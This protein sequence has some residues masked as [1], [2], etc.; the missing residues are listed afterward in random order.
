MRKLESSP[1]TMCS[2]C[3]AHPGL[4]AIE[5][6]GVDGGR[7][8]LC[9]RCVAKHVEEQRARRVTPMAGIPLGPRPRR[10]RPL[11]PRS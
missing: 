9:G 2:Q 1:V 11:A 10:S 5:A 7:A 4:V 8:I 3:G 6:N